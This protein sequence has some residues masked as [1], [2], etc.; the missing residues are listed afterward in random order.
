M[1]CAGSFARIEIGPV[2]ARI[3]TAFCSQ[4]RRV[5][6]IRP[7]ADRTAATMPRHNVRV[8]R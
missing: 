3:R 1:I 6:G 2:M 7:S 4:C 5:V 8:S